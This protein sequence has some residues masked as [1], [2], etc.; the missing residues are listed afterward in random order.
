MDIPLLTAPLGSTFYQVL[1]DNGTSASIPLA[2]MPSLI[3]APPL[4]L[5]APTDSLSDNSSSLLWTFLSINSWITYQHKGAYHKGFLTHKS[6][7]MYC[8]SFKT[9][10]KKKS[11]DWG[12]DLP[13]L[14]F[15]WVDLCTKGIL[16]PGHIGH[17][18][19]CTSSHLVFLVS[20]SPSPPSTVDPVVSIVSVINLHWDCPP[21]LLQALAM[22]HPYWEVWLQSYSKEKDGIKSLGTFKCLTLGKYYSLREKGTPMMIPTMCVLTIKKDKQL[23]PL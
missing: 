7:G 2:D 19:I 16:V 12:V 9:R 1:F 13:N 4:P 8:S 10:A 21:S 14:P 17:S 15:S 18:F 23:M 11:E 3:L 22:L 5:L 6:C 20:A